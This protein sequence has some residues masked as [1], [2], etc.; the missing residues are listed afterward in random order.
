MSKIYDRLRNAD[1]T[2][3]EKYNNVFIEDTKPMFFYK[4]DNYEFIEM[5]EKEI[6]KI[7]RKNK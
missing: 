3:V 4:T 1:A 5:T 2:L 7:W 6:R